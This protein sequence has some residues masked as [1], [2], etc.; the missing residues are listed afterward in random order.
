MYFIIKINVDPNGSYMSSEIVS[1]AGG[2]ITSAQ[3][4]LLTAVKSYVGEIWGVETAN[5]IKV[6][7]IHSFDQVSEP[8]IDSVLLYRLDVDPH[9]IHIYQRKSLVIPGR[10]YGQIAAADFRKIRIFSLVE[11]N[12]MSNIP[13]PPMPKNS[14]QEI[15][16]VMVEYG[17]AKVR[18]PEKNTVAPI[19]DVIAALK[20]SPFFIKK[21]AESLNEIPPTI[22][23]RKKS[24]TNVFQVK[25]STIP[26]TQNACEDR[27]EQRII[28]FIKNY[29][30]T[31][32]DLANEISKEYE[33]T[34]E[35]AMNEI[36]LINEKFPNIK[37]SREI[38]DVP[39][40]SMTDVSQKEPEQQIIPIIM[41]AK[42]IVEEVQP[43][44]IE[45]QLISMEEIV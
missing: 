17:P 29:E 30:Y 19:A 15:P 34:F 12:K 22:P 32:I 43:I 28:Y 1:H 5:A 36:K 16:E 44:V 21:Y 33:I 42:T 18:V 7:D 4:V 40:D 10:F 3:N 25:N 11:Y 45:A 23:H 39:K 24:Q 31:D 9:H 8:I 14:T 41:E 20:T 6:I 13:P 27:I 2:T 35:C 37:K 38:M 26:V